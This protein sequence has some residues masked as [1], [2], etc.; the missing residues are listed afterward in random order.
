MALNKGSWYY[1]ESLD[2][3]FKWCLLWQDKNAKKNDLKD[4]NQT[5]VGQM[6]KIF[7]IFLGQNL[8]ISFYPKNYFSTE[9]EV[10]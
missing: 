4:K 9:G 2:S 7:V 10:L 3:I 8:I 6:C 1:L 5:V